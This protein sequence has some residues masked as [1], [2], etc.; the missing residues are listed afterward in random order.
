MAKNSTLVL[1][2]ATRTCVSQSRGGRLTTRCMPYV[3]VTR[4][5]AGRALHERIGLWDAFGHGWTEHRAVGRRLCILQQRSL[6]RAC[7]PLLSGGARR[8]LEG[9]QGSAELLEGECGGAEQGEPRSV[10][11]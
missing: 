7:R 2:K 10:P 4:T 9:I 6:W 8:H 1:R 5:A 3:L 11:G